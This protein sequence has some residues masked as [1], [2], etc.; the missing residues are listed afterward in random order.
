MAEVDDFKLAD[1]KAKAKVEREILDEKISEL[2]LING[3]LKEKITQ[4]REKLRIW[5]AITFCKKCYFFVGRESENY[6][7]WC[8]LHSHMTDFSEFC[9]LGREK[10]FYETDGEESVQKDAA[11]APQGAR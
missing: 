3:S 5:P 9:S 4:L 1:F 10:G 6:D 11:S 7:G 8:S 2:E